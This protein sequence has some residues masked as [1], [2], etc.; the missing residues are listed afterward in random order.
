MRTFVAIVIIGILIVGYY[1]N[2]GNHPHD[3]TST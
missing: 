1:T 3:T 2:G